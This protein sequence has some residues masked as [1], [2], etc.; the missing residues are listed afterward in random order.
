MNNLAKKINNSKGSLTVEAAI[1]L[2]VFIFTIMAIGMFIKVVYVQELIGHAINDAVSEMASTSYLYNA[3]GVYDLQKG[4]Q[5]K[6]DE[7]AGSFK[8]NKQKSI[9]T[10][11]HISD[12]VKESEQIDLENIK[13]SS[14]SIIEKIKVCKD[15]AKEIASIISNCAK[16]PSEE[17]MSIASFAADKTFS[18]CKD[19]VGNVILHLYLKKYGLDGDKLKDL[20][21]E[22]FSTAGSTYYDGNE[23]IDVV[24]TYTV[25]IP[26]PFKNNSIA[27]TQR[28]TARAWMAGGINTSVLNENSENKDDL[29]DDNDDANKTKVYVTSK[30]KKYH[31]YGCNLIFKKLSSITLKEAID[32]G[33]TPCEICLKDSKENITK[34]YI[35]DSSK[36]SNKRYHKHGCTAIFKDIHEFNLE[37]AVKSYEP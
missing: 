11:L 26:V 24:V 6:L 28:A 9:E 17:I 15:D 29:S 31:R 21:V 32:Q 19:T 23:D 10:Y 35:T 34:V 25:K 33:Y 12:L 20:D 18:K 13:S 14:D 4:V 27:I 8:Q 22:N 3:S 16:N 1:V 7:K 5:D 2:P 36:F 37:D 30:G